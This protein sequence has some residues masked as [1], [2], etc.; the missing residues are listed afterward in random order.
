MSR[1]PKPHSETAFV[2]MSTRGIPYFATVYTR[3]TAREARKDFSGQLGWEYYRLQ[4]WRIV[5]VRIEVIR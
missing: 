3:W 4:G 1:K 2:P 5:K